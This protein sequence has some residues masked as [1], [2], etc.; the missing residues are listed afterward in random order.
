ME[1]VSLGAG[2]GVSNA[3]A[4]PSRSLFLLPANPNVKL[5][6]ASVVPCLPSCCHV[7]TMMTMGKTSE[8]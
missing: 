8:L 1:E 4:K 2:F 7:S 3:Q 5:L 6:T